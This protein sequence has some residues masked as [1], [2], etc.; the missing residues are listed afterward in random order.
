MRLEIRVADPQGLVIRVQASFVRCP[1]KVAHGH[2]H[3]GAQSG[4]HAID[5]GRQ[6]LA[7]LD[8]DVRVPGDVLGACKPRSWSTSRGF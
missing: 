5:F 7:V 3:H 8:V 4:L 2:R 1:V 6:R